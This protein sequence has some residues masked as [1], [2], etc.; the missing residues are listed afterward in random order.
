MMDEYKPADAAAQTDTP[1]TDLSRRGFTA[2]SITAGAAISAAT[3]AHAQ[4]ADVVETNVMIQTAD[5]IA[6]A[7]L[8]H[9]KGKGPWPGVVMFVDVLGLRPAFRDMGRRLA[10]S[11][12]TVLVPNPFYRTRKAPVIEGPFDFAN[13][14]DFAKLTPLRAP[15]TPDAVAR[16]EATWISYLDRQPTVSKK[17]KMGVAGY[18]MGGPMVMQ[19]AALAPARIG[20]SISCHGGGVVTDK[21]DSPHLLAAKIKA[22]SYFAIAANDAMRQPDQKDKL[23]AAFAAAANPC[24]AEVYEG[25][26]HGWCVPDGASYNKPQ[27]ERAWAEMLKLYKSALV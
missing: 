24:G 19:T 2:L 25:A 5:G 13:P 27:A 1:D 3:V 18:C 26:D 15:L 22:K 20:A 9:P 6:D 12:Y 23:L 11:G 8:Y 7:A 16:D 14:A 10:S 21:P 17:A 4:A